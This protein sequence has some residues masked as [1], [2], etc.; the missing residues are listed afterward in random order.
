M[1]L[2]KPAKQVLFALGAYYAE[3]NRKMKVPILQI[4]V[5]KADFIR[6]LQKAKITEKQSRTIYRS[7]EIL[8]NK[9]LIKY[10]NRELMLTARGLK[11][12]QSIEKDVYPY[13]SII[14]TVKQKQITKFAR[15]PQTIFIQ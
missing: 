1:E 14:L 2:S 9:K 15:K 10:Q 7:L 13:L 3:K 11:I 12:F 6:V 5:S 4:A 8:E